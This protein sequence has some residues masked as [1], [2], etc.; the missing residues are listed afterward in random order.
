ML[1]GI[2]ITT[3]NPHNGNKIRDFEE[4]S[5]EEV[6]HIILKAGEAQRTWKAES[7]EDRK[8]RIANVAALLRQKKE[9]L[10]ELMALEMG[11]P[12][13]QGVGEI[14]KCAWLCDHYVENSDQY[15][16]DEPIET[17]ATKSYV[18]FQP[19]GVVLSI[20]PWNFPFWQLMRFGIPALL[21]GNGVILKHAEGT[22][23]CGLSIEEIMHEAGI[24][25]DLFRMIVVDKS[26][27]KE[28]IQH[29]GI[30]AV[31]FTGSTNA[32]KIIASQAGEMLKKTVLE[33]GGSD[34]YIIL[35]DADIEHAAEICA[36]SRLIN[37][38]QSCVAAKRFIVVESVYA[39]FLEAFKKELQSKKVGNPFEEG[40]DIG[41]MARKDLQDGLHQQVT[42][43]V[44]AGATLE[45]GGEIP[46]GKGAYYPVTLLTNV[47][48]GMPAYEE[49]LFGPV[50]AVL[51]VADEEEAIYVANDSEYGLGA[52]VFSANEDRAENIAKTKLQAGCCFVNSLVK[53]D[54]RVPFGGVKKSGY[55]RELGEFGIR[56]F[57]NIKTVW[58]D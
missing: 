27:M 1:G 18:S 32:G 17:D 41:P 24:P 45:F 8:I 55:G 57:V 19:L 56:E 35:E 47:L 7:L 33:L 26:N 12:I 43:S 52:A 21:A 16:A 53:S 29:E 48:K 39:R 13:A 37:S 54:P 22:T 2:L 34:P 14:E 36:T 50:A 25:K 4:H 6:D 40:I 46:E 38:G 42:N 51:K 23:G 5:F 31:T 9:E 3:I 10:A 49:E 15:L 11:K 58:V 20:M 30:A 44:K 28:V